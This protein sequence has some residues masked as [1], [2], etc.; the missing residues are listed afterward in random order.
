M[1]AAPVRLNLGCG[2]D[3]KPGWINVDRFSAFHPDVVADLESFP[4]PWPDNHADEILMSHV[5]E[6]LGAAPD[7]YIGVIKELWRVCRNGATVQIVVPH[8]RHDDFI[9]DPTHVRPVTGAGL[10]LFSRQA[11]EEWTRDGCANT[12]L[13]LY[14][15][16][17]FALVSEGRLL[18]EPWA[19]DLRAGKIDAAAVEDAMRRFNNV[20]KEQR[21][22]LR[23]IK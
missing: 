13:A 10:L 3:I 20:I 4:W 21:F 7:T 6:H 12:P 17:D 18:E 23:A 2:R 19:Q 14:H 16:V 11:N 5:L 1:S 9:S 8:P 22:V 15:G